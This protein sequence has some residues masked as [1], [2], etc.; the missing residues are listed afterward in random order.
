M[1]IDLNYV[2]N[3]ILTNLAYA[4][5]LGLVMWGICRLL[6]KEP[7][8]NYWAPRVMMV[9][10][11]IS[12]LVFTFS[13]GRITFPAVD[14]A[15][16]NIF[17]GVSTSIASATPHPVVNIQVD[18]P[19][20]T[21]VIQKETSQPVVRESEP[22]PETTEGDTSNE[23]FSVDGQFE[24]GTPYHLYTIVRG[25]TIYSL[26]R[27]FGVTQDELMRRNDLRIGTP[28]RIG[29]DLRIPIK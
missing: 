13:V 23:K 22:V 27:R 9:I 21:V 20:P 7:E 4:V 26:S 16:E 3:A 17:S 2:V 8:G 29:R 14:N 19:P 11:L 15:V 28:L 10:F 24:D 18:T 6:I 1:Q 25:N 12:A 5:A